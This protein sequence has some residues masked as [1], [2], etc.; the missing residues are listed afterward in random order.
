MFNIWNPFALWNAHSLTPSRNTLKFEGWKSCP[1][2]WYVFGHLSFSREVI[3]T[4]NLYLVKIIQKVSLSVLL[5]FI[6]ILVI[7][8]CPALCHCLSTPWLVWVCISPCGLSSYHLHYVLSVWLFLSLCLLLS[9]PGLEKWVTA[10]PPANTP[11]FLLITV[12]TFSPFPTTF[13]FSINW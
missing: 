13:Y 5:L 11:S 10:V 6:W 9:G 3:Y 12:D 7:F 8:Q 2:K 4:I 1:L